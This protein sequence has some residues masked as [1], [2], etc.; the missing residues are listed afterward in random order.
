MLGPAACKSRA[1]P[2]STN[3]STAAISTA[4]Q[5]TLISDG[6]GQQK[7]TNYS[8]QSRSCRSISAPREVGAGVVGAGNIGAEI[9]RA[10]IVGARTVGAGIV[11]AGIVGA[12]LVGTGIQVHKSKRLG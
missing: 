7:Q 10:G 12:G 4:I 6:K 8:C 5:G 2:W 9:V 1:T 3:C 11:V